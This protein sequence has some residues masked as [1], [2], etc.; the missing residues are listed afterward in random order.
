MRTLLITLLI[1]AAL[2][3]AAPAYAAESTFFGP[4]VPEECQSC[5]CGFAGVL[6]I[7][8]HLM[9]FAVSFGIIVL[10]IMLV[11]GGILFIASAVNPESRSKAKSLLGGAFIGMALI[12]TSWLIVDFVMRALYSGP[13]GIEGKFGPWNSILAEDADWCIAAKEGKGFFEIPFMPLDAPNA[14]PT[15]ADPNPNPTQVEPSPIVGNEKT[16]RQQLAAAGIS[17]NKNPCPTGVRYQDVRGGCTTVG[18]LRQNTVAQTITLKNICGSLIVTGGNE[19]GHAS[20]GMSHTTGYKVDY[21]TGIDAC[22]QGGSGGYFTRNGA[23]GGD[24]RYLDKCGNEY[25]RES[26]PPHWDVT[27]VKVCPK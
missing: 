3:L 12:L 26:N 17:V 21:G 13:A 22:I 9:N 27:V 19:L 7:A 10:T 20:G 23:R 4:I 16:V 11:W 6:E 2:G 24:P 18:G 14:E 8:R 5:P 25:V 1:T 15:E